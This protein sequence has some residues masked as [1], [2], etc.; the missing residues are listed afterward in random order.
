MF[1]KK[2]T[3]KAARLQ[4]FSEGGDGGAGAGVGTGD[5]GAVPGTEGLSA[6]LQAEINRVSS[7]RNGGKKKGDTPNVVY[8]KQDAGTG[9]DLG[10][11]SV[12]G[13]NSNADVTT[14]SNTLEERRARYNEMTRKGGE[15]HDLFAEDTQRM[16]NTRFK[17]MKNLENTVNT[18]KPIMDMLMQKYN[19]T[20]GDAAKLLKAIET[21]DKYW[22]EAAEEAGMTVEQY[23]TY[24]KMA[25]ENEELRKAQQIAQGRQNMENQLQKWYEEGEKVKSVYPNFDLRAE[26]QNRDFLQLL[27]AGIPIQKAYETIH[28]DELISGASIVSARQAEQRTVN[29]IKNRAS[30]PAENINSSQSTTVVKSDPSKF[31]KADRAE[32]IRQVERGKSIYL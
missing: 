18:Q 10:N 20:D 29:N 24:Q 1:K 7:R 6:S 4:M 8:G 28:L 23:R 3:L 30:R 27:Q 15:Y 2:I 16:I 26:S 22:E 11:G 19:I 13:G 17:E 32:I 12:A 9:D 31:T 25:R 21:D 14:T 5:T